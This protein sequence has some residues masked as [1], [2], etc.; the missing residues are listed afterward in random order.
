MAKLTGA[1]LFVRCL[2]QEGIK[3]DYAPSIPVDRAVWGASWEL[4]LRA[5]PP[6]NYFVQRTRQ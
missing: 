4:D 6:G 2:K 1:H 5:P 3:A